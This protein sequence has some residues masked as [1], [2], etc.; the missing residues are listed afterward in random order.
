MCDTLPAAQVTVHKLGSHVDLSIYIVDDG[1][2]CLDG[3]IMRKGL[4][5]CSE[6]HSVAY[7]GTLLGWLNTQWLALALTREALALSVALRWCSG[8]G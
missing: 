6:W 1:I 7:N 8:T 4:G 5:S 3:V 2:G